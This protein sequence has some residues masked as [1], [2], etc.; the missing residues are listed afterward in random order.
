MSASSRVVSK[1]RVIATTA[2]PRRLVTKFARAPSAIARRARERPLAAS[3]AV[4]HTGR[5]AFLE[6]GSQ[7]NIGRNLSPIAWY[8]VTFVLHM[9]SKTYDAQ[10]AVPGGLVAF[11]SLNLRWNPAAR[12]GTNSICPIGPSASG[13]SLYV[14]NLEARG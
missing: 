9:A 10:L 7:V 3:L 8:Q 13:S 14:D 5:M 12:S 4:D 11:R 2:A 1:A 6:G